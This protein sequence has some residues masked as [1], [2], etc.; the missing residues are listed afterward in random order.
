MGL[1]FG[2][3]IYNCFLKK[4]K[5]RKLFTLSHVILSL[6]TLLDIALVSRLNVRFDISDEAMVLFGSA[7]S[8]AIHQFKVMPFLILSGYLC[9]PEGQ[10]KAITLQLLNS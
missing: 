3:F 10:I 5:L 2:T 6:T 9:P 1:L 4:I 8:D 7:L